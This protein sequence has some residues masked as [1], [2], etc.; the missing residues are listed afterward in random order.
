MFRFEK[1]VNSFICL[2]HPGNFLQAILSSF[3]L[4]LL[5]RA[6]QK[7]RT[8]DRKLRFFKKHQWRYLIEI[9]I[10]QLIFHHK[11]LHKMLFFAYSV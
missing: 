2:L 1:Y 8:F 6:V 4:Q 5:M 3:S 10:E 11:K 7:A 9:R